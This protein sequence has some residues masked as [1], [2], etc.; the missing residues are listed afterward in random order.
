MGSQLQEISRPKVF[1]ISSVYLPNLL[2][3]ALWHLKVEMTR[4][5][6]VGT[7]L[8]VRVRLARAALR[9]AAAVAQRGRG[10]G[11]IGEGEDLLCDAV[12]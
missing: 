5:R 4:A 9:G 10:G 3:Y 11:G 12:S 1:F 7:P 6:R 8:G 2:L